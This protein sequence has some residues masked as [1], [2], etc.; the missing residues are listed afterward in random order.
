[1]RKST[2][3]L[4]ALAVAGLLA[5]GGSAFTSTGVTNNAGATQFVGG[6]ISQNVTGA[7]LSSLSAARLPTGCCRGKELVLDQFY[8]AECDQIACLER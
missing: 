3:F 1:M 2:K 4:G 6:T 8:V 7:T 5:A